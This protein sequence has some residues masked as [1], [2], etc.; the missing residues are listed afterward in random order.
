MRYFVFAA[1]LL[2]AAQQQ[3]NPQVGSKEGSVA[4]GNTHSEADGKQQELK[5][6]PSIPIQ[7]CDKCAVIEKCVGCIA[8]K[9]P[10]AKSKQYDRYDPRKDTLYRAYLGFTIF[11]VFV[12]IG[13]IA[14]IYQQTRATRKAAEATQ[15]SAEAT[16]RSAKATERSVKL[17][18]NTQRQWI[19]LRAWY[20]NR[21]EPTAPLD[22]GFEIVNPTSL[23]LTLHG[24]I[25]VVDGKRIDEEA[26][27][28][29]VTPNDPFLHSIGVP[30]SVEQEQLYAK[31]AL[32]FQIECTIFFADSHNIHWR[33]EIGS[34]L[35]CG[36]AN[37]PIVTVTKNNLS[38][39][40]VPGER[41][42]REVEL[43]G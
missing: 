1:L 3:P 19:E 4:K 5:R 34:K 39:S 2:F 6:N 7:E 27:V 30:L 33:Q 38:E 24:V 12:A 9:E 10:D 17:Q 42:S 35:L 8:E 20:V 43:P 28:M 23:P 11:G 14:A 21:I 32:S 31:N 29:L 25:T 36:R 16:L 26:P 22:V 13:G 15:Q 40:G 41:G 18:E 37:K